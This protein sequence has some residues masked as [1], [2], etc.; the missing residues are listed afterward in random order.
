MCFILP[1]LTVHL[2]LFSFSGPSFFCSLLSSNLLL[3]LWWR[4][5][6][7]KVVM[8]HPGFKSG[9]TK[10]CFYDFWERCSNPFTLGW[11]STL[12]WSKIQK[13]CDTSI[14]LQ[15]LNYET[16]A[17]TLLPERLLFP[18]LNT[19]NPH[20]ATHFCRC[21]VHIR[22]FFLVIIIPNS[23]KNIIPESEK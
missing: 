15:G 19:V 9:H 12:L 23:E 18:S 13:V 5:G 10:G 8:F 6:S 3:L 17:C 16:S 20:K 21:N 2:Y 14:G 11:S 4:N 1:L 22:F 7:G